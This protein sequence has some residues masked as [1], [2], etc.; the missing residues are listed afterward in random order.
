ML[1]TNRFLVGRVALVIWASGALLGLAGCAF[2]P[3]Y[4]PTPY[5]SASPPPGLYPM[6][7]MPTGVV[8]YGQLVPTVVQGQYWV[9]GQPT[10]T[11]H[12]K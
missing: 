8:P 4:Q 2:E 9:T 12:A 5:P 6:G 1:N 11:V 3:V 10:G 7:P